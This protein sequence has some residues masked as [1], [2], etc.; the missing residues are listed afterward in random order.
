[1]KKI[2]SILLVAVATLAMTSCHRDQMAI[3][4]LNDVVTN[5]E[6]QYEQMSD[7]DMDMAKAQ[8]AKALEEIAKYRYSQADNELIGA[9]KAR[10]DKAILKYEILDA[11]RNGRKVFEQIVGY[12]KELIN[13]IDSL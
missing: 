3:Q 6:Q 1:M 8:Y 13:A 12:G 5:L 10:Y 4:K 9:I 2:L 11:K 7:E